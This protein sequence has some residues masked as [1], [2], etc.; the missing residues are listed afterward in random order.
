MELSTNH[1]PPPPSSFTSQLVSRYTV[2]MLLNHEFFAEGV[3]IEA[4]PQQGEESDDSTLLH[5]R[6]EVPIKESSKKNNQESIEF[7]FDISKDQPEVVVD[8]MV[9][10]R[11]PSLQGG[12]AV[13]AQTME[14]ARC[15]Y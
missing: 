10:P 8:M 7:M 13:T 4:L 6:L 9:S 5:L 2:K 1:L 3:K 12:G 15:F 14:R 11:E